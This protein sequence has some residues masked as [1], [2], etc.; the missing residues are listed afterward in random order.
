MSSFC[1]D[2]SS[3]IVAALLVCASCSSGGQGSLEQSTEAVLTQHTPPP[4]CDTS[5]QV[6]TVPAPVT[7]PGSYDDTNIAATIAEAVSLGYIDVEFPAGIYTI[8]S[9]IQLTDTQIDLRIR[10]A[11]VGLTII[12]PEIL[13]TAPFTSAPFFPLFN[14]DGPNKTLL[15]L[16]ISGFTLEMDA[17][18]SHP[19]YLDS[20]VTTGN[21][22]GVRVGTGWAFSDPDGWM[23]IK[24]LRI[25]GAP[26]Y[27]VGIQTRDSTP[28]Y[29]EPADNV[30]LENVFIFRTGSDGVDVKEGNDASG[31]RVSPKNMTLRGVSVDTFGLNEKDQ[32]RLNTAANAFDIR[33]NGVYAEK[34][35]AIGTGNVTAAHSADLSEPG[36]FLNTTTNNGLNFRDA[37][38][39]GSD[40][41][42][43]LAY[44][45]D[46]YVKGTANAI[47]FGNE[48]NENVMINNF[49]LEEYSGFGINI[50]GSKHII[51]HGCILHGSGGSSSYINYVSMEHDLA[52]L[53]LDDV[54]TGSYNPNICPAY[55]EV[56][57]GA[58]VE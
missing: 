48:A 30:T 28:P 22:H 32:N 51:E 19:A 38:R 34:L 13:A 47:N 55:T 23:L 18:A 15:R 42:G 39:I 12:E 5:T 33:A 46:L 24:D 54:H 56:G 8:T 3:I 50:R 45:H 4:Y 6:C 11:G 9:S 10:G 53:D 43:S 1:R 17:L 44:V 20:S 36:S 40:R 58:F 21:A 14:V 52:S 27:G 31:N 2:G 29:D 16:E 37:T 57:A 7:A 49:I 41:S 25:E 35:T 26:G